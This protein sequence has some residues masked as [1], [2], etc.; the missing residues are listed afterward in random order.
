MSDDQGKLTAAGEA[1]FFWIAYGADPERVIGAN[2]SLVLGARPAVIVLGLALA[3]I[4]AGI[5][6]TALA[7]PDNRRPRFA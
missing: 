7:R 1:F 6:R 2:W 3:V 5:A 4:A